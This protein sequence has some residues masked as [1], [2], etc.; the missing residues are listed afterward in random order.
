MFYSICA[1]Y[2]SGYESP[3]GFLLPY[4]QEFKQWSTAEKDDTPDLW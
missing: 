3:A 4:K 2:E 1:E